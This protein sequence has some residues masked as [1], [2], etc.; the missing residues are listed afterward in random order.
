MD[1]KDGVERESRTLGQIW[2]Q[3][4]EP[5]LEESLLQEEGNLLL[6]LGQELGTL[7]LEAQVRSLRQCLE[8]W[9]RHMEE[10]QTQEKIHSRLCRGLGMSIGVF[11]AIMLL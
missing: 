7:D 8:Q 4:L 3:E 9:H 1:D 6:P 11:F 2:K 5:Y 10:L